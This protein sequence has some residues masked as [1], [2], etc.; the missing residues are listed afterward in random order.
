MAQLRGKR[1]PRSSSQIKASFEQ[2][3]YGN[4][5]TCFSKSSPTLFYR[6]FS[7]ICDLLR[8]SYQSVVN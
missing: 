1:L 8:Q 6:C 4:H 3:A 7:K 2:N 5:A